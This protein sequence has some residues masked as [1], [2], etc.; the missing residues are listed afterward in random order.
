MEG[1]RGAP[2]VKVCRHLPALRCLRHHREGSRRSFRSPSVAFHYTRVLHSTVPVP[3]C[4]LQDAAGPSRGRYGLASR[5]RNRA[6][7]APVVPTIGPSEVPAGLSPGSRP[8]SCRYLCY[9][10]MIC[11][12]CG[13]PLHLKTM[14]YR[15]PREETQM[16]ART[17][18][19][20]VE[21]EAFSCCLFSYFSPVLARHG[22]G[23]SRGLRQCC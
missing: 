20:G 16:N 7:A 11:V 18:M 6:A 3:R 12:E 14:P 1:H 23:G 5:A 19:E 8:P 13:A 9:Y 2:E 17:S 21:K 15:C 4:G 10:C 22:S